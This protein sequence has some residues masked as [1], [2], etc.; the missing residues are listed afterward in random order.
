MALGNPDSNP[1]GGVSL[2]SLKEQGYAVDG[3]FEGDPA[4]VMSVH[5]LDKGT[6]TTIPVREIT[7]F[8]DGKPTTYFIPKKTR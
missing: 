6:T 1:G 3:S 2:E 5:D 8:E 7:V 4:T